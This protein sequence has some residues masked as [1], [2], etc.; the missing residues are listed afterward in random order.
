MKIL[1]YGTLRHTEY[2]FK[3]TK[4]LYGDITLLDTILVEGFQMHDLLYYPA[5]TKNPNTFITAEVLLVSDKAFDFISRMEIGAGYTPLT[6]TI[7]T[8]GLCHIFIMNS[9]N[10]PII[11]SGDWLVL[12][13]RN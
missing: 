13:T 2:N 11:P 9:C 10:A 1:A 3:R 6:L 8:H 5:I 7:P 4:D 12:T